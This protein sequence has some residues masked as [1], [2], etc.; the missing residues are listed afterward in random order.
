MAAEA[1]GDVSGVDLCVRLDYEKATRYAKDGASCL[2]SKIVSGCYITYNLC[3]DLE[4]RE[5]WHRTREF[6]PQ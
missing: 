4:L 3:R 6:L 2:V 1:K 5:T